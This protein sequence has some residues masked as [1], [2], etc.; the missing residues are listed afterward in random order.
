[1][2]Q[3]QVRA[4]GLSWADQ[5]LLAALPGCCPQAAC[6]S[7]NLLRGPDPLIFSSL[8]PAPT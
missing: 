5:V 8:R 3:R 6:A 7:P 4:P 1:V 2:L